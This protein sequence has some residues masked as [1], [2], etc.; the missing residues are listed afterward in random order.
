MPANRIVKL[1]INTRGEVVTKLQDALRQLGYTINDSVEFFGADTRDAVMDIQ[2]NNGLHPT[3]VVTPEVWSLILRLKKKSQS[4]NPDIPK[5]TEE[6]ELPGYS[7]S[8]LILQPNGKPVAGAIV[9]AFDRGIGEEKLLG[10]ARTGKLGEYHIDYDASALGESDKGNADLIVRV[11]SGSELVG[12]SPLLIEADH[13]AEVNLSIGAEVYRGPSLFERL[14]DHLLPLLKGQKLAALQKRDIELLAHRTMAPAAQVTAYLAARIMA[15]KLSSG[16]SAIIPEWVF[17]LFEHDRIESVQAI[18]GM[19]DS[20]LRQR[21]E[22]SV[23]ANRIPRID[24]AEAVEALAEARFLITTDDNLHSALFF[25]VC[26]LSKEQGRLLLRAIMAYEGTEGGLWDALRKA[27]DLTETQLTSVRECTLIDE[28]LDGSTK[29]F[30]LLVGKQKLRKANGLAQL[31]VDAWLKAIEGSGANVPDGLK[32]ESDEERRQNYARMLEARM[33][34]RFASARFIAAWL[35]DNQTAD[36]ALDVFF[37]AH[38]D[39]D[40]TQQLLRDLIKEEELAEELVSKLSQMENLFHLSP[41]ENRF[42]VA[43]VLHAKGID[44]YRDVTRIGRSRF[45]TRFK[46]ETGTASGQYVY[47][48]A[49]RVASSLLSRHV[50]NAVVGSGTDPKAVP[51]RKDD[52]SETTVSAITSGDGLA[53]C[54][55]CHSVFSPSAYLVD[56]LDY[57]GRAETADGFV[58]GRTLL[59]KRRPDIEQINLSC[60]N[61]DTVIPYIDLVLEVLEQAVSGSELSAWQTEGD[62]GSIAAR[63]EHI[64]IEAYEKLA[65]AVYPWNLPFDRNSETS[66]RLL[67]KAGIERATMLK[68]F[69]AEPEAEADTTILAEL[70][71]MAEAQLTIVCDDN[72][73]QVGKY[74]GVA[75]AGELNSVDV[76]TLMRHGE[77]SQ[78][79]VRA[80]LETD[81]VNPGRVVSIDA[82]TGNLQDV[83]RVALNNMQRFVR[84]QRALGVSITAL[85][86]LLAHIAPDQFNTQLGDAVALWRES[87]LALEKVATWWSENSTF[88]EDLRLESD[89]Y[90]QLIAMA[91]DKPTT[92]AEAK[93]LFEYL[94]LLEDFDISIADAFDLLNEPADAKQQKKAVESINGIISAV[95]AQADTVVAPDAQRTASIIEM[96]ADQWGMDVAAAE[97]RLDSYADLS[98]IPNTTTIS[99]EDAVV[100]GAWLLVRKLRRALVVEMLAAQWD[101]DAGKAEYLL[102][103]SS[104]LKPL[105]TPDPVIVEG[106]VALID[107]WLRAEKQA[108]LFNLLGVTVSDMQWIEVHHAACGW[109]DPVSM[110]VREGDAAAT[111]DGLLHLVS[112]NVIGLNNMSGDNS[113]YA[114]LEDIRSADSFV[115]ALVDTFAAASKWEAEDIAFLSGAGGYSWD[116]FEDFMAADGLSLLSRA[117]RMAGKLHLAVEETWSIAEASKVEALEQ[118]VAAGFEDDQ[119]REISA[120]IYGE[121]RELQRKA[122]L[123]YL[124]VNNDELND[125]NEVY[126][127]YLIDP[128]MGPCYKTSRIKQAN[129]SLQQFVQ[130]I[131]LRMESDGLHFFRSDLDE[132]PWRKNYRVWEANRKV[133]IYPENWIEP[134]LRDDKSPFFK[135]L[136]DKLFQGDATAVYVESAVGE[137][138]HSLHKVANLE[139]ASFYECHEENCFYV[140]ARTREIPHEYYLSIRNENDVWEPWQKVELDI[141]GD[142]LVAVVYNRRLHLFWPVFAEKENTSSENYQDEIKAVDAEIEALS[143]QLDDNQSEL[144]DINK[145]EKPRNQEEVERLNNQIVSLKSQIDFKQEQKDSIRYRYRYLEIQMAWSSLRN[146]AWESKKV[147]S[148]KINDRA[149]IHYTNDRNDFFLEQSISF[150]NKLTITVRRHRKRL[151]SIQA[152][153]MF[154]GVKTIESSDAGTNYEKV[155]VGLFELDVCNGKMANRSQARTSAPFTLSAMPISLSHVEPLN[156]SPAAMKYL[157]NRNGSE[158]SLRLQVKT[159]TPQLNTIGGGVDQFVTRTPLLL[160]NVPDNSEVMFSPQQ[161]GKRSNASFF[162]EDGQRCYLIHPGEHFSDRLDA[163]ATRDLQKGIGATSNRD[164][165]YRFIG[166]YHPFSCLFVQ[167]LDRYGL[168]GL[169]KPDADKGGVSANLVRQIMRD[170]SIDFGAVYD[171]GFAVVNRPQEVIDFRYGRPYANYNWELFYHVPMMIATHLMSDQKFEEAQKWLHYIF[172]PMTEDLGGAERYWRFRPFYEMQLQANIGDINEEAASSMGD[173]DP[174]RKLREWEKNPFNPH[175]VAR[176]RTVAYMRNTV[177]KYLDNLI[178]WADMLFARDTME[179]INEAAQLYVLAAQIMGP[180]PV[181]LTNTAS[182]DEN[183]QSARELMQQME[184]YQGSSDTSDANADNEMQGISIFDTLMTFCIPPNEK[185]LGYWDTV[186]DRLFKIRHCINIEGVVRQLPLFEPPID[187]ALLVRASA[188]GVD[189]A[190]VI[191][192]LS[193]PLPHYRF[194]VMLQKSKELCGSVRALGGALLSAL[195]KQDAE[196]IAQIRANHEFSLLKGSRE[197]RR[198]QVD[199]AKESLMGLSESK[200]INVVK[201]EHY[202]DIEKTITEEQKQLKKLALVGDILHGELGYYALATISNL[203]PETKVGLCAGITFGGRNLGEAQKMGG[204]VIS[205][206]SAIESHQANKLSIRAGSERRW[207]D[208][209]LQERLAAK[210][211]VQIDKQIAGAEIRKAIAEKELENHEKQI[212]NSRQVNEWMRSKFTN[213]EIYSWMVGQLSGLYFQ[214]YQLAVEVARKA[215]LCYREE[216]DV[217]STS[218]IGFGFWDSLKKGLL[219]GEQLQHDLERMDV[220]YLNNNKRKPEL[221][222]T[223]SLAQINPLALLTLKEKGECTFALQ[224]VIYNLDHPG[225]YNRKLKSV[226]ISLPCIVGPYTTVGCTLVLTKHARRRDADINSDLEIT[227]AGSQSIATS[228]A[229]NDRGMFEFNFRDERYLP[230]E[231]CGAVS[232]WKLRLPNEVRQFDY[233]SISDVI[234]HVQYTADE[235][236]TGTFRAEVETSLLEAT[237]SIGANGLSRVFSLKQDFSSEWHRLLSSESGSQQLTLELKENHFP[238]ICRGREIEI[239]SVELFLRP[240]DGYE[241]NDGAVSI[242]LNAPKGSYPDVP[243]NL[244]GGDVEGLPYAKPV[245]GVKETIGAWMLDIA[246]GIID[247]ANYEDMFVCFNY[248]LK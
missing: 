175:A 139:I 191:S 182:N 183:R 126:G 152:T 120:S 136:E 25:K 81:F 100:I 44:S 156:S 153:T 96:L 15:E 246:E 37:K 239:S 162:Y 78:D 192:G 24:I 210:E 108:R 12:E 27:A 105:L 242:T 179:S 14:D 119:W 107:A 90:E 176:V 69:R 157:V 117:I 234:L 124:I 221:T 39:H 133:F 240:Q 219:A 84:L 58:D 5:T 1:K 7:V 82:V 181:V 68:L 103:T 195:E 71:G 227:Y 172:D 213:K 190:T 207:N 130:R 122:L 132:W 47:A 4:E 32:G 233:N 85:D 180:K 67:A 79:E 62:S 248:K 169:Y 171:P 209:K 94:Q 222:K 112:D 106:D 83:N 232:E 134:E 212:E 49:R 114:C 237:R 104:E 28:L 101:V 6:S 93:G 36:Q 228:S 89:A 38:P 33:A 140:I 223:V 97:Q 87:G 80:L 200:A 70:L 18:G 168:D 245:D 102:A 215:E 229:Q 147:S 173:S 45:I 74:W 17:G 206:L 34:R 43:K 144:D 166:F 203:I 218:F 29:L 98:E 46:E 155:T 217:E 161:E 243:I 205:T 154:P 145:P 77:L 115:L 244:A 125:A 211:L 238:Y 194:N 159:R 10:E 160:K 208:W 214:T 188:A 88:A 226:G 3:G 40:F 143:D 30:Q 75:D 16:G 2:A 185:M 41:M 199:E 236:Q 167:H 63:P 137:Y 247:S 131:M 42:A 129:A 51:T 22:A 19:A 76:V 177:M 241:Y 127:Y 13:H 35:S 174:M 178:G 116:N 95:A 57:I 202:R 99:E 21:L 189:L 8:G 196:E 148:S 146:G 23:H 230:F 235:D 55:H 151:A 231:N 73:D 158:A 92:A 60:K 150:D 56:L 141:E 31:D 54:D 198:Q 26:G 53:S 9:K 216:L 138:L 142:H 186:A 61:S 220:A 91:G 111:L 121:L 163:G 201:F 170:M 149:P 66:R 50:G 72:I 164:S 165:G 113:I 11:F 187:P 204:A 123:G 86:A 184:L 197:I 128:E 64:T 224:E 110:P 65:E 109:I 48:Q 52:T 59:N 118:A 20:A 135:E 225:H 193:A